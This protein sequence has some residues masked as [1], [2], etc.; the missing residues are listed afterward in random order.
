VSWGGWGLWGWL[1]GWGGR[2]GP[3]AGGGYR[4]LRGVGAGG[5]VGCVVRLEWE[6][7]LDDRP[8][9]ERGGTR[10]LFGP[11]H[12]PRQQHAPNGAG[13][14]R[15]GGLPRKWALVVSERMPAQRVVHPHVHRLRGR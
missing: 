9:I 14:G 10:N 7:A 11:D 1:G 12:D 13:N 8:L 2:G 5:R 15:R 4:R 6:R 3:Y